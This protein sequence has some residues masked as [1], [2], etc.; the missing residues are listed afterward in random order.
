MNET[1]D[2]NYEQIIDLIQS[3]LSLEHCLQYQII[4]L[5]LEQDCLTLGMVNPEDKNALDFVRSRVDAWGY[6]LKVK[7][8]DSYAHQLVLAAY[9]KH[10]H[11]I[12]QSEADISPQ[13]SSETMPDS[14]MTVVGTPFEPNQKNQRNDLDNK[15]TIIGDLAEN[16]FEISKTSV[17]DD[18][19]T[20]YA[21]IQED[22]AKSDSFSQ[23]FTDLTE[24]QK[25][26]LDRG[27]EL[28]T[29]ANYQSEK[30]ESD[31]NRQKSPNLE[32]DPFLDFDISTLS[33]NY[34][35]TNES[36]KTLT[37][38][39]LWQELFVNILNGSISQLNLERNHDRGRI[40][41][42]QDGIVQSSVD[43]VSLSM[44]Q[45]LIDEIKTLAK[46]PL[47]PLQKTRKVAIEKHYRQERLQLR[48]DA[49]PSQWGDE[50]TI[51]VL[52]GK[53]L[54]L[55]EQQQIKKM[56]EQAILLAQKLTKTL[57]TMHTCFKSS[58]IGNLSE[59]KKVQQEL[60]RQLE[61]IDQM[62]NE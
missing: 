21:P 14:A 57:T 58:E 20:I 8:I 37:P 9:L 25:P 61:L 31:Q 17:E 54:K 15:A 44:F 23:L 26:T 1:S 18:K 6:L 45:A 60:D 59:L 22:N 27:A 13:T 62:S 53:A 4:P 12:E 42:S 11:T 40:L 3:I 28:Q 29:E 39:E 52:R 43:D 41:W 49:C 16:P 32:L 55:H 50:I 36:L 38:Q 19:S 10:S 30:S 48:I 7:Q 5:S 46:I 24:K 34:C 51:Q 35:L 56:S 47:E 33:G 2:I